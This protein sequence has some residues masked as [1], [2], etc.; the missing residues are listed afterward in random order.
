[1]TTMVRLLKDV[2]E[3]QLIAGDLLKVL[4]YW[5]NPSLSV[6][7]VERVRDGYRPGCNLSRLDV[8][9]EDEPAESSNGRRTDA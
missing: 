5:L 7:V 9:P 8:E 3:H 2:P 1:M 6:T 4:P